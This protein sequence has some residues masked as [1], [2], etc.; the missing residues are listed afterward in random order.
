MSDN[1][2]DELINN[3][4]NI[5]DIILNLKKENEDLKKEIE[6]IKVD[7]DDTKNKIAIIGR[8]TELT[9]EDIE[10]IKKAR[11]EGLSLRTIAD[12]IDKSHMTVSRV[13]KSFRKS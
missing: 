5:A 13:L 10:F 4:Q 7:I 9:D 6:N 8:P 11:A 12:M 3:L 2:Y 1:F